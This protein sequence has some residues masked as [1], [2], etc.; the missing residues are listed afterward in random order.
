MGFQNVSACIIV[1]YGVVS[2]WLLFNANS[3]IVQL[4]FNENKFIS[5]AMTMNIVFEVLPT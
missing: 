1:H 4:Y 2:E 5:N 3:A